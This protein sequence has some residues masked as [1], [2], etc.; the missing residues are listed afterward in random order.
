[1]MRLFS[2]II[3][4]ATFHINNRLFL[5]QW[6]IGIIQGDIA[7]IIRNKNFSCDINWQPAEA[8]NRVFADPFFISK[9]KDQYSLFIEDYTTDDHYGKIALINIG[10]NLKITNHRIVLDTKSHL[11]YPFVFRENEKVYVFPEAA[12]S[13]KLSCYEFD[14]AKSEL[15]FLKHIIDLP[16]LD[17]N[18]LKYGNMYWIIGVTRENGN[19][20]NYELRCFYSDNL[21]GPYSPHA[22]NPLA[23]GLDGIRGA[24]NMAEVDGVLYRPAQNCREDYGKS[25]TINK[26]TRLDEVTCTWEPHMTISIDK[27]NKRN[28]GMQTIHTINAMGDMIIVDGQK[29]TFSPLKQHREVIKNNAYFRRVKKQ[30]PS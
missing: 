14:P 5:K 3:S 7:D 27:K 1:M 6:I 15:V 18:V 20:E 9:E 21:L 25:I 17:S 26:I 29:W 19:G 10:K 24:G 16:L 23:K 12:A 30:Q 11:S 28:K 4:K 2:K 13:G 22:A 8:S